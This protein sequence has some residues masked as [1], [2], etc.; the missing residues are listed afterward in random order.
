MKT[1]LPCPKSVLVWI[2]WIDASGESCRVHIDD[3]HNM[4]AE[5]N[6]NVGW[7]IAE[8]DDVLR[9]AHGQSSTGEIDCFKIPKVNIVER[10]FIVPKRCPRSKSDDEEAG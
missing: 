3:V 10:I 7:I 6:T 8:N 5:V 9:L 2:R 1:N 4:S